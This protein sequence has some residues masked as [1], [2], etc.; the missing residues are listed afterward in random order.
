M[1]LSIPGKVISVEDGKAIVSVGGTEYETSL[2]LVED[3]HVGD[4]LL[5]HTG[6]ALEKISEE[7][8]EETLRL[9]NAL[10]DMNERGDGE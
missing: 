4:Y 10:E 5:I 9:F 8:A 2:Q 7:E 1:C 6:F 3:V